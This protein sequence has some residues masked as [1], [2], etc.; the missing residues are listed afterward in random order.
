MPPI[1]SHA[2]AADTPLNPDRAILDVVALIESLGLFGLLWLDDDLRVRRAHGRI[3]DFVATGLRAE[4]SLPALVGL[5]A[6]LKALRDRPNRMIELPALSIATEHGLTDKFNLTLFWS[7]QEKA[8]VALAYRSAARSTLETELSGQIRARLMAEAEATALARDLARAN[9]DLES[10]AAIVSH[11][12]TAPL[13][14][15]SQLAEAATRNHA[16]TSS[17]EA[18]ALAIV[19]K[20]AKHMQSMLGRLFDY[21]LLGRKYEA[22]DI[23]DTGDLVRTTIDS[24]PTSRI[25]VAI[26]GDWPTLKTLR[27]PLELAIRNLIANG[28]QHHD[29]ADGL[30]RVACVDSQDAL[31][32]TVLDDGPGISIEHQQ[33]IFLPFRTLAPPAS[34][35]STGMGLAMVNRAVMSVGGAVTVTSNPVV[36]RGALFAIQW[37]KIITFAEP[38]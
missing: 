6:D 34:E 8:V 2:A 13:R 21:S 19:A 33:I 17:S 7:E 28:R 18:S 22:L 11:D 29:R 5:E 9:A 37:P 14:H 15:M 35:H 3:F 10:F 32:I 36:E 38:Q 12:L 20:Q 25:Q 24:L 23:V 4:E 16:Q 26:E 27:A 30:I 31:V 1:P